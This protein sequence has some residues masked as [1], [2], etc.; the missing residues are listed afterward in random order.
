MTV[1][2]LIKKI[3]NFKCNNNCDK[4]IYCPFKNFAGYDCASYRCGIPFGKENIAE[5]IKRFLKDENLKK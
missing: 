4:K 1:D 3:E 5:I 2:E